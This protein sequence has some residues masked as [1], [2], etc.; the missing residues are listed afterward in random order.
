MIHLDDLALCQ[1]AARNEQLK[2]N[3]Q[4]NQATGKKGKVIRRRHKH[5]PW[6]KKRWLACMLFGTNRLKG[7]AIWHIHPV[8]R[9]DR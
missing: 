9:N 6:E 8:L 1:G 2:M 7:G 4:G 5:N 3:H